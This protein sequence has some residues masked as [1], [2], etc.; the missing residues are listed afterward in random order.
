M[1]KI[2]ICI[3]AYQA[4]KYLGETLESVRRQTFQD[5]DLI[6]VEDGMEELSRQR[7]ANF[8]AQLDNSVTYLFNGRNLGPSAARN[9]AIREAHGTYIAFLDAD[10]LWESDHLEI[11]LKTA[12]ANAVDFVYSLHRMFES[13]TDRDLKVHRP[14][15]ETIE[16]FA[17][18]LYHVCFVQTSA[19]FI[20]KEKLESVGSF[21]EKINWSED[22]DLYIRCIRAGLTI[23]S[24]GRCTVHY[25]KH[26]QALTIKSPDMAESK[27]YVY[28][29]H[30]DFGVIPKKVRR[31]YTAS[32]FCSAGR[33]RHRNNPLKASRL[34]YQAWALRPECLHYLAFYL[35]TR[36]RAM[37][38]KLMRS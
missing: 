30:Y 15:W 16:E 2:S 13:E 27:A 26:K 10:D 34:F 25:R 29:K 6:F 11:C 18:L 24:T 19:V 31:R 5:W 32:T 1:P 23:A 14:E 4:E 20:N 8:S 17:G 12:G 3:P 21:D 22:F 28:L 9:R 38:L 35:I 37:V 33:L 36:T 7:I